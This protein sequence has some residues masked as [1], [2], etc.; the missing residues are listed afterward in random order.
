VSV[1]GQLLGSARSRLNRPGGG[2]PVGRALLAAGHHAISLRYG[3]ASLRPGSS[4]V[5]FGLGPLLVSSAVRPAPL[6]AVA[7]SRAGSLCGRSFDWIAAVAGTAV[8]D[9]ER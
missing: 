1:D 9:A 4:G 7:P 5:P 8:A 2:T 3:G 6:V